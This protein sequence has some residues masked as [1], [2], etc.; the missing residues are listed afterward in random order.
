MPGRG[1]TRPGRKRQDRGNREL[2]RR[3]GPRGRQGRDFERRSQR[4]DFRN[5]LDSSSGGTESKAL[6]AAGWREG[7]D[8]FGG[9]TAQTRGR[10]RADTQGQK[11]SE[12]RDCPPRQRRE[13]GGKSPRG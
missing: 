3:A 1:G 5:D 13:R 7:Q 8:F 11:H 12:F 6:V 10:S 4:Q 2:R 9:G